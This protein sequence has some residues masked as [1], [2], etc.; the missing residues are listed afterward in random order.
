MIDIDKEPSSAHSSEGET[1]YPNLRM[2]HLEMKELNDYGKPL[3][4]IEDL[5]GFRLD[6]V[7]LVVLCKTELDEQ[8]YLNDGKMLMSFAKEKAKYECFYIFGFLNMEPLNDV[9]KY[10]V[11]HVT[12]HF[13]FYFNGHGTLFPTAGKKV[14]RIW[15]LRDILN[16]NNTEFIPVKMLR[17]TLWAYKNPHNV[18]TSFTDSC[19]AGDV[20]HLD[21][22]GCFFRSGAPPD[23]VSVAACERDEMASC[24]LFNF[25]LA[26]QYVGPGYSQ[27]SKAFYDWLGRTRYDYSNYVNLEMEVKDRLLREYQQ[28]MNTH[29]STMRLL[30]QAIFMKRYRP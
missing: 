15:T 4:K 18:F 6:Y 17:D 12:H 14:Y 16:H 7:L 2:D 9:F 13:I 21:D 19:H 22:V 11:S 20:F 24:I 28:T 3:T 5:N 27:F 23:C 30:G 1:N 29:A 8:R 10:L 25:D 26:N